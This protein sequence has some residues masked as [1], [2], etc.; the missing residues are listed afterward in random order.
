[1]YCKALNHHHI[2]VCRPVGPYTVDVDCMV[3]K[4]CGVKVDGDHSKRNDTSFLECRSKAGF[5]RIL[6]HAKP[7]VETV[8]PINYEYKGLKYKANMTENNNSWKPRSAL[9]GRP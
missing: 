4:S 7:H 5:P 2:T 1:M 6:V 3:S 8:K 9:V